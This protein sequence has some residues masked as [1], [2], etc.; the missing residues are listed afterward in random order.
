MFIELKANLCTVKI[1]NM[2]I[3]INSCVEKKIHKIR[4]ITFALFDY[5][6][7]LSS[8]SD[9]VMNE[10]SSKYS[11]NDNYDLRENVPSSNRANKLLGN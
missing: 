11:I 9:R 7:E 2:Q 10:N 5:F 8:A 4:E 1:Q 3:R 6:N